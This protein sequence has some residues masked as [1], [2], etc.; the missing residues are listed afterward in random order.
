MQDITL[1]EFQIA[2][3]VIVSL[4]G[5]TS[6]I[7]IR[8]ENKKRS[9][10]IPPNQPSSY[11][12]ADLYMT[13]EVAIYRCNS[14]RGLIALSNA[15]ADYNKKYPEDVIGFNMLANLL[16]RKEIVISTKMCKN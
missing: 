1:K 6:L 5:I 13:I 10:A 9:L 11:G 12:R 7:Q 15:V 16:T 4:V 8:K 3:I 2:M 14:E